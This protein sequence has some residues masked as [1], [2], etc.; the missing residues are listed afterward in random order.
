MPERK[1]DLTTGLDVVGL[2]LVSAGVGGGLWHYI[3]PF[4]LVG[5]GLTLVFSSWLA[6][7]K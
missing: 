3:G 5:S 7:R 1:L 4:G 6:A 2:G